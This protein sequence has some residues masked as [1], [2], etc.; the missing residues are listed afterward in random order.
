MGVH[1]CR[2][3][4]KMRYKIERRNDMKAEISAMIIDKKDTV[5]GVD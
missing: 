2:F 4:K 3:Q 1:R 5:A